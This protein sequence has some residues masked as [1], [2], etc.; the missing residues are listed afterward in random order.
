MLT[1]QSTSLLHVGMK[2]LT[3]LTYC[4]LLPVRLISDPLSVGLTP[5]ELVLSRAPSNPLPEES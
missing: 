4:W 5:E 1:L 2:L 3:T